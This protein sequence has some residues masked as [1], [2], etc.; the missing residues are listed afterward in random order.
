MG[1][2]PPSGPRNWTPRAWRKLPDPVREA[3]EFAV[4]SGTHEAFLVG[5]AV[6]VIGFVAAFFVKEVPLR[7]A[8]PA[9]AAAAPTVDKVAEQV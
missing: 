1:P 9:P 4:A 6:A 3:Y 8:G 5:A 2:R 7:G